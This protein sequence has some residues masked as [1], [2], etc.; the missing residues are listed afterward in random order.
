MIDGIAR[1]LDSRL[2]STA[3]PYEDSGDLSKTL[4]RLATL[5]EKTLNKSPDYIAAL[6]DLIACGVQGAACDIIQ[7]RAHKEQ[8]AEQARKGD[9]KLAACLLTK[10][11]AF[12]HEQQHPKEASTCLINR[13][14]CLLQLELHKHAAEDCLAALQLRYSIAKAHFLRALALKELQQYSEGIQHAHAAAPAAD[15]EKLPASASHDAARLLASMEALTGSPVPGAKP[16]AVTIQSAAES[17]DSLPA[18]EVRDTASEGRALCMGSQESAKAGAL[19]MQEDAC[20]S[21]VTKQHRKAVRPL[22]TPVKTIPWT[23]GAERTMTLM[24]GM[25]QPMIH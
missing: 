12:T 5:A 17:C 8:A 14:I 20:V 21:A 6:R 7:A 23:H 19:L 11:L 13:A 3:F 15:T 2:G 24:H 18:L 10:A 9:F 25:R 22:H 16:P 4:H 1:Q